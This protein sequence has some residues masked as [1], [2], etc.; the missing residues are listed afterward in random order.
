FAGQAYYTNGPSINPEHLA[1]YN[2][3]A[4]FILD[5]TP[6]SKITATYQG[7]A[8]D[9]DGSGQIPA[10]QVAS[11]ALD[12]FRSVDP[13]AG[14]RSARPPPRAMPP[15]W[16]ARDRSPRRRWRAVRSIASAPSIPPRAA[17]PIART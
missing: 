7:Y 12:R 3:M 1:R 14:R 5:P 15:T 2:G 13:P 9:W 8:A 11:G 6:E 10:P 17:A 4:R 16:T